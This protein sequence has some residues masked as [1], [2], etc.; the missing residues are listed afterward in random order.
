MRGTDALERG[1]PPLSLCCSNCLLNKTKKTKQADTTENFTVRLSV[2]T[3][4]LDSTV[5]SWVFKTFLSHTHTHTR[6]YSGAWGARGEVSLR[7]RDDECL[8]PPA[9]SPHLIMIKLQVRATTTKHYW[10]HR[11]PILAYVLLF[12][13]QA[14]EIR[15]ARAVSSSRAAPCAQCS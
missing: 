6:G 4:P 7:S 11:D 13:K 3:C 12:L 10:R 15:K 1:K 2:H 8:S 14:L 5:F 9:A